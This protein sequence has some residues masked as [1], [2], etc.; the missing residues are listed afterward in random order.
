MPDFYDE[1]APYYH[2]IFDDWDQSMRVQGDAL[3]RII[4]AHWPQARRVLDV[5][6]GIGTQALALAQKNYIVFGSDTS[7]AALERARHEARKRNLHVAFSRRDMRNS[8]DKQAEPF[9]VVLCADNALPHLLTDD[10]ILLALRKMH[11]C[12]E[13]RGGVIITVRDY[14]AMQK[15]RGLVLSYPV[16]K[17]DGKRYILFQRLDFR[18]QFCA[19]KFVVVDEEPDTGRSRVLEMKTHYYAI[20]TDRLC[21]LMRE[22]GFVDVKRIDGAFYQP[23]FVG[24]R[25]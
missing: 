4:D 17:G 21:Q 13:P 12:L 5:A 9:H 10:D 15:G 23:V 14:D 19:V 1:L 2:L 16:R 24:T 18:G 8:H 25:A 20:G 3:A 6:C 11:A 7:E 22:A